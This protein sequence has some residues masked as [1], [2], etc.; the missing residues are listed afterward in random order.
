MVSIQFKEVLSNSQGSAGLDEIRAV[1]EA[2]D[3]S[4]LVTRLEEYRPVGRKGYP[5]TALW[6]AYFVSFI[7][8]LSSTNA[9]IRRLQDDPELRL[10]CGFSQ[11]P[12]RT[13]FNRFISRLNNHS[14]LVEDCHAALTD[15][16]AE[17]LPG[18]GQKVAVDSTVVRTHSN[19]NRKEVSDPEASW[20]R[21]NSTKAKGG[22]EWYWGYKYH[23]LADATHGIPLYGYTTTASRNDSP[24][25]PRLLSQAEAAHPWL[26]PTHVMADKG[27]D[28]RANH[29]AAAG[30]DAILVCPARRYANNRLYEGIYTERGVPTC[31]GMVEME[32]VDTD[33]EK[34]H[35]YRCPPGGCHLADRKGVR[36]CHD[37]VW[38]NRSDNPRL[39]GPIRQGSPEWKTLY[40]LR[41]SVE[42]VFKSMKESR[43]LERHFVRGLRRVSL[44]AS[45]STLGFVATFLVKLLA[46]EGSPRWMVR[47]VA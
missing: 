2:V 31:V 38:V 7:L 12:H 9:L 16:L 4:A 39:F 11:L 41:Q 25:L 17:L 42:R 43:R 5:L 45:M 46:G 47:R 26:R 40:R 8:G 23:L 32:Y 13:T 1:L 21:K 33:P 27:Y 14:D 22:K 19:P 37:D 44:H 3:A 6:R 28:S 34:G 36:Y 29:E 18:L 30:R 10:L 35:L 20:T 15:R 24:E